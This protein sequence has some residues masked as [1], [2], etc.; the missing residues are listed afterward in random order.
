[1]RP[2][3]AQHRDTSVGHPQRHGDRRIQRV[4]E[5]A[6]ELIGTDQI[7]RV[8]GPHR[9]GD[10]RVTPTFCSIPALPL[11]NEATRLADRKRPTRLRRATLI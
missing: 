4:I 7:P 5:F 10:W 1:L 11:M 3:A 6:S 9:V 8:L 2:A